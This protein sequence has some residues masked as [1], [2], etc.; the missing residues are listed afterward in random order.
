MLL[1]CASHLA[2]LDRQKGDPVTSNVGIGLNLTSHGWWKS[3]KYS[4]FFC[5]FQN[6]SRQSHIGRSAGQILQGEI[7]AKRTPVL[8]ATCDAVATTKGTNSTEKTCQQTE[9]DLP[10]GMMGERQLLGTS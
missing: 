2:L 5:L 4:F 3:R 7:K 6:C 1:I 10:S 9:L 8:C